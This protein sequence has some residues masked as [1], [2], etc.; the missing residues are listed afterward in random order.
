MGALIELV[1][2]T[3]I[4]D[5]GGWGGS[6]GGGFGGSGFGSRPRANRAN[7]APGFTLDD[8]NLITE[9]VADVDAAP[10]HDAYRALV[11][12]LL[13]EGVELSDR[14]IVLGM[15]AIRAAALLDRR[16]R[17]RLADLWPLAHLW[18]DEGDEPLVA[19]AVRAVVAEDPAGA[20]PNGVSPR[21][22]LLQANYV[23]ERFQERADYAPGAVDETVKLLNT[24]RRT[25]EDHHP[26]ALEQRQ[27]I[28]AL[29]QAVQMYYD[30]G[31]PGPA[32]ANPY[33][34]GSP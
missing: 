10:V 11:H 20:G 18:T 4:G 8:L 29:S 34:P 23:F 5:R 13:R 7:P 32:A 27:E 15:K 14:R 33:G 2:G 12:D 21:E 3:G 26:A 30:H 1:R 24:L 31:G 25:L 9:S 6:G 28:T 16:P 22:L 17:A 19:E